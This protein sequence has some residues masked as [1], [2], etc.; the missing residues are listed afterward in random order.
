MCMYV[1][2]HEHVL[3][4]TVLEEDRSLP[5]NHQEL[6]FHAVMSHPK[7]LLGIKLVSTGRVI[8]SLNC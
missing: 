6:E 3:V 1:S 5:H 4:S 8:H 7:W 2:L